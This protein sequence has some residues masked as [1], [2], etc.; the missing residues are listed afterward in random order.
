MA[1]ARSLLSTDLYL[2]NALDVQWQ[3][4]EIDINP[5]PGTR[6]IPARGSVQFTQDMTGVTLTPKAGY[7]KRVTPCFLCMLSK[8]SISEES[9]LMVFRFSS[10]RELVVL[11]GRTAFPLFTTRKQS[12]PIAHHQCDKATY[13][14]S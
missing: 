12:A 11:L 3:S 4:E 6:A 14:G 9:S 2:R 7:T 10:I 8:V 5:C 1:E 13:L